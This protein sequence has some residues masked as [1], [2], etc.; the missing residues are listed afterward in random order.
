MVEKAWPMKLMD[1]Q[2]MA[3][4]ILVPHAHLIAAGYWALTHDSEGQP[5]SSTAIEDNRALSVELRRIADRMDE[6]ASRGSASVLAAF[7]GATG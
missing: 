4:K 1:P 5:L 6:V 2:R 7:F 3:L